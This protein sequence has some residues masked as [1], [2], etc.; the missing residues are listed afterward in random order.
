MRS[1]RIS[2]RPIGGYRCAQ[3]ALLGYLCFLKGNAVNIRF[4]HVGVFIIAFILMIGATIAGE[5]L[6]SNI[7]AIVTAL[8]LFFA[9]T[10]Y[11]GSNRR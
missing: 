6:E 2:A 10:V 7:P 11:G 3:P 5:M 9:L 1:R 8:I 4:W